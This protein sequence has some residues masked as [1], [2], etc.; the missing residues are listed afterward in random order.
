MA[1]KHTV[2]FGCD[3]AEF[4]TLY[5]AHYADCEHEVTPLIEGY[6]LALIYNLVWTAPSEPPSLKQS[7]KMIQKL[8]TLLK[9]VKFAVFIIKHNRAN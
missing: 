7:A 8:S 6:R 1:A 9:E 5:A 2:D 3:D 4:S